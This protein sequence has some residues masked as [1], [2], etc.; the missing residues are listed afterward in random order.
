M[1]VRDVVVVL[2]VPVTL[3]SVPMRTAEPKDVRSR[4]AA[5]RPDEPEDSRCWVTTDVV[6]REVFCSNW[7]VEESTA[8]VV[9]NPM[10]RPEVLGGDFNPVEENMLVETEDFILSILVFGKDG[11]RPMG[12]SCRV[13]SGAVGGFMAGRDAGAAGLT[14]LGVLVSTARETEPLGVGNGDCWK[15][16]TTVGVA[17]GVKIP[18][19]GIE[20]GGFRASI[21]EIGRSAAL[22]GACGTLATCRGGSIV[23]GKA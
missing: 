4:A 23:F 16:P 20:G 3:E 18:V 6:L 22:P 21:G 1:D 8:T 15:A 10:P 13:A 11:F 9:L 5:N 14:E 2:T 12:G 7:F 17:G 19:G